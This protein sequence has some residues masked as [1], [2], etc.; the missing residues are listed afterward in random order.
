MILLPRGS[1]VSWGFYQR[2][3]WGNGKGASIACGA[4]NKQKRDGGLDG[5]CATARLLMPSSELPSAGALERIGGQGLAFRAFDLKSQRSAFAGRCG[6][7]R[8]MDVTNVS[9]RAFQI[10]RTTLATIARFE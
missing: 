8:T 2:K 4:R 3:R 10:V 6:Q 1:V 7:S 9:F 5:R